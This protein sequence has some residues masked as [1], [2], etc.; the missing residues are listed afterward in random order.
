M[1]PAEITP[2]ITVLVVDDSV[3]VRKALERILAPQGYQVRM[4]DSAENALE[5]LEP[6]LDQ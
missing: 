5:T 4:A 1:N 3:S 2:P 6:H